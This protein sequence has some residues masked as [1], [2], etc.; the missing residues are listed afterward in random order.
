MTDVYAPYRERYAE[1]TAQRDKTNA[2]V[3]DKLVELEKLNLAVEQARLAAET[4]AKE[5][6]DAR[7]GQAW[8]NLKKEIGALAKLLSGK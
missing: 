5:I 4:L 7:G 2:L 8:L 6:S 1:L 3:A